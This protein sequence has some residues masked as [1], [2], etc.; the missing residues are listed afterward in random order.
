M[1]SWI[2]FQ[3]ALVPFDA[4]QR[5]AGRSKYT[6]LKMFY[7]ALNATFSFSVVPLRLAIQL[8]LVSIFLSLLYLAYILISLLL[9]RDVVRGWTSIIFLTAFLGG[10]QLAFIG[11]VGEYI[12][13]IFEEV[14]GRP[15]YVLK[16]EP[17]DRPMQ[18]N[19][20]ALPLL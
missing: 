13:R 11:I 18:R 2:G 6:P 4:P 7:L 9:H 8:G 5:P 1:V 14:K 20:D 3:R 17:K 15:L 16:Q 12:A 19:P 10:V